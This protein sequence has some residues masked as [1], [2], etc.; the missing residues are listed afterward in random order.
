M[1]RIKASLRKTRVNSSSFHFVRT[2]GSKDDKTKSAGAWT[3][4]KEK[5]QK[6][7]EM[8]TTVE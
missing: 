6:G 1:K 8:S 5:D 7:S 2:H 3:E 4:N